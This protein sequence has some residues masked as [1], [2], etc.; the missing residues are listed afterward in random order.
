MTRVPSAIAVLALALPSLH[1][2]QDALPGYTAAGAAAQRALESRI[3]AHGSADTA[4]A[5]SKALSTETHIAGTPA[6]ARTR[7][8][9][10]AAMKRWGM[11]TETREY[12]I[13]MPHTTRMQVWRIAPDTL[14]LDLAEGPVP[15]DPSSWSGTE[16]VIANGYS[17]T[18]DVSAPVVYVNYG[19]IEDYAQLD[20]M[21]ISVKGKIA[22]AR[23]GRSF[24]GIK[25]R[26]A[27]KHGAVGLLIYS[28]PQDD[29]FVVGDV[30]PE[31]PMRNSAGVQRGSI[32][33]SDGDPST[34]G[35]GSLTA[36][37]RLTPSQM[38]IPHIPVVPISYGNAA[39]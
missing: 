30:Y 6:Q 3:A 38:E 36:A 32:L 19:L 29:G 28:D 34:P 24:R 7:D 39:E 9:V 15:A 33:N 23:Y 31:G 27:E 13:W 1:A 16:A 20:S 35:Y 5:H 37:R 21:G 8:Y 4:R 25:A 14:A 22:I 11:E 18:G 17:G 26:E 10:L 2:Q 12:E